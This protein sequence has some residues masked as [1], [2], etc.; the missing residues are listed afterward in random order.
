MGHR[1]NL[2]VITEAGTEIYYSHWAGLY[3]DVDLFWGPQIATAF[4][5][6][7]RSE[8]EGAQLL[9]D[10]W[11]EGGAVIDHT[12]HTLLW[13]G[14]E[15]ARYDIPRR[16]LHLRLM[17]RLWPGWT[18]RWA[19]EG[20]ADIADY[21]GIPRE[22]LLVSSLT[23]SINLS[24][25]DSLQDPRWVLTV[26]SFVR[27]GSLRFLGTG[28][29][30]NLVLPVAD[31]FLATL[32]EV[33]GGEPVYRNNVAEEFPNGGMHIDFDARELFWWAAP[34]TPGTP[35]QL[36]ALL[37]DWRITWW[38]DEYEAH[39]RKAPG[40]DLPS[41][42]HAALCGTLFD[43]LLQAKEVGPELIRQIEDGKRQDLTVNPFAQRHDALTLTVEERRRILGTLFSGTESEGGP[44][45]F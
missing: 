29:E 36:A 32:R 6:S 26:I 45:R 27:E 22:R 43:A 35:S 5:R 4:A 1:A 12:R 20:V 21:L 41:P 8:R 25:L 11:C 7:Q 31:K 15:G 2:V 14:G 44:Y 33:E 19:F 13:F 10:V 17:S 24:G 16:R 9:N 18:I 23:D 42:D 39:I 40:M 3:L 30:I 37:P 34:D 28:T 38:R